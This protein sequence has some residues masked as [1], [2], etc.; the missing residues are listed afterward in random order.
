MD[1]ERKRERE[2]RKFNESKKEAMKKFRQEKMYNDPEAH[3]RY[4]QKERERGTRDGKLK[5]KKSRI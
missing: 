5:E 2:K 1:G 3:E 4:K